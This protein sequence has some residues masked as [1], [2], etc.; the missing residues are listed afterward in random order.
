MATDGATTGAADSETTGA[1][2]WEATGWG[3]GSARAT[4]GGGGTIGRGGIGLASAALRLAA[5]AGDSTGRAPPNGA[6]DAGRGAGVAAR[7][8]AAGAGAGAGAA[9]SLGAGLPG[10]MT[11]DFTFSTTTCL[12]RPWEKLWRTVPCSVGRFKD[13]VFVPLTDRVFSPALFGSLI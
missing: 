9:A 10:V 11:R 7:G 4:G 1:A 12:V 6:D 8:G 2:G 3:A 13:K 5:S